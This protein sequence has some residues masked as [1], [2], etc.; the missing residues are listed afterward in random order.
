MKR[1]EFVAASCLAGLTPFGM[2][3]SARGSSGPSDK[4]FYELRLYHLEPAKRENAPD[5]PAYQA[6]YKQLLPDI[7]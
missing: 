2:A 7:Y 5:L 1:R 6:E 4:E 3:A